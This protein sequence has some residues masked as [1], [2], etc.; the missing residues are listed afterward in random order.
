MSIVSGAM[1]VN[2]MRV[3]VSARRG[4]SLL[5]MLRVNL[6]LTGAKEGCNH[7]TCGACTVL[8]DGKPVASC[9]MPVEKAIGKEVLTVE[10]LGSLEKLHPV[11]IAFIEAGAVQCGFCTSG[12]L[13]SAASLL[14]KNQDPGEPEITAAISGNLCRCT[15]YRRIIDA[16]KKAAEI[17]RLDNNV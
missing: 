1:I 14:E 7:G 12:M 13:I 8:V 16:I 4:T 15:G 5:E 10:G 6:G 11:Q 3:K 17:I 9:L 2:G